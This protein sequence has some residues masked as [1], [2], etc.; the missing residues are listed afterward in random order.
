MRIL[1]LK[2][3]NVYSYIKMSVNKIK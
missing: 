2:K 3:I 1:K